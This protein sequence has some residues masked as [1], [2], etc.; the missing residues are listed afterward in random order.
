MNSYA[1]TASESYSVVDIRNVFRRCS[2]DLRMIVDSS[3]G[4]SREEIE[5]ERASSKHHKIQSI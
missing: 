4:M 3:G 2:T 5:K 1:I